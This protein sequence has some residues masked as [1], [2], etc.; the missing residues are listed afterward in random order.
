[1]TLTVAVGHAQALNGREA[2]LQ[3]AHHALNVL[4]S[5]N[6]ALGIVIAS[7]Q[8]QAREVISDHNSQ[9]RVCR[10]QDIQCVVC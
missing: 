2:G 10:P 9:R 6:P 4:G 8:Y 1:M 3:S 7:H 5:A